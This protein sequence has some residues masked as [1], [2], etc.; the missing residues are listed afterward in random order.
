MLVVT[1]S[2]KTRIHAAHLDTNLTTYKLI[3]KLNRSAGI[4]N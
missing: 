1:Y 2:G 4:L 3:K